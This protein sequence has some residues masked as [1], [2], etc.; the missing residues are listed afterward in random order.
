MKDVYAEAKRIAGEIKK[1]AD[2]K[3]PGEWHFLNDEEFGDVTKGI[4]K[5]PDNTRCIIF[6]HGG[7]CIDA[8]SFY[9]KSLGI[10]GIY[11]YRP[12]GCRIFFCDGP[13]YKLTVH[14]TVPAELKNGFYKAIPKDLKKRA[15]CVKNRFNSLELSSKEARREWGKIIQE[16]RSRK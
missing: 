4:M 9:A 5:I 13:P 14:N 11:E 1:N 12:A 10:C 8:C 2:G 7:C 16:Y 15:D 6:C 3:C